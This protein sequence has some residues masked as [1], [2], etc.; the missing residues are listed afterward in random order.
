[1][2]SATN[3]LSA[4]RFGYS[5]NERQE[6]QH[7]AFV[8]LFILSHFKQLA[9]WVNFQQTFLNIVL[10]SWKI[11]FGI[12]CNLHE[13]SKPLSL[14]IKQQISICRLLNILRKMRHLSTFSYHQDYKTY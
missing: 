11:G 13:M 9:C 12:S 10:F 4:L 8:K 14:E 5:A 3:L 2:S 7:N 6:K 1:M